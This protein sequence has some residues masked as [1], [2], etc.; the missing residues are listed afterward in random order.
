MID[1]ADGTMIDGI[2]VGNKFK[3]HYKGLKEG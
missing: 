3:M 1:D 2:F